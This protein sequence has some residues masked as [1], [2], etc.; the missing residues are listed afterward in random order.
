MNEIMQLKKYIE[1]NP[2]NRLKLVTHLGLTSTSTP[3]KWIKRKNIPWRLKDKVN[4]YI[5][6][7]FNGTAR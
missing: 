2:N 5:E 4:K 3:S 1:A 7:Y 6:R